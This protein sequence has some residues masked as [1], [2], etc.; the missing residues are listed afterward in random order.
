M[1]QR[2]TV[3]FCIHIQPRRFFFVTSVTNCTPE[4]FCASMLGTDVKKAPTKRATIAPVARK[5][6]RKSGTTTTCPAD[7]CLNALSMKVN[8]PLPP[9]PDSTTCRAL[10][11]LSFQ[12]NADL[13]PCVISYF[14]RAKRAQYTMQKNLKHKAS[15]AIPTTE[16]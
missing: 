7:E 2:E 10:L 8:K 5:S 14:P 15:T 9:P 12:S 3:I 11:P 4:G 6:L 1:Q 13:I 16:S